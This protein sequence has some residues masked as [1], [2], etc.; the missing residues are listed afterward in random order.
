VKY[1]FKTDQGIDFLTQAAEADRLAGVRLDD[2]GPI[3]RLSSSACHWRAR[4]YLVHHQ[5]MVSSAVTAGGLGHAEQSRRERI[6]KAS[7]VEDT[8]LSIRR[9]AGPIARAAPCTSLSPR[10]PDRQAGGRQQSEKDASRHLALN[11]KYRGRFSVS[12]CGSA[13]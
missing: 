6:I 8:K 1:H 9:V 3:A 12:D 10:H 2:C 13:S 7:A 11:F 5:S 4:E